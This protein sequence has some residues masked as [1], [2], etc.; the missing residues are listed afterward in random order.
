GGLRDATGQSHS[1]SAHPEGPTRPPSSPPPPSKAPTRL[2]L[3]CPELTGSGLSRVSLNGIS[4]ICAKNR[5]RTQQNPPCRSGDLWGGS[6]RLFGSHFFVSYRWWRCGESNPG[7]LSLRR[8][9]LR[10]QSS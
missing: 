8:R 1:R 4:D 3:P 9:H 6:F 5:T 10:A 2:L 7:P